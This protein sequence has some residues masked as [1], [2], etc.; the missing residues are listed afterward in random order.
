M[1]G[2]RVAREDPT[3][4]FFSRRRMRMHRIVELTAEN[5]K[6][7]RA[8]T[9]KPD[10]NVVKISGANGAGKS[11]IMDAARFA[12]QGAKGRPADPVRHGTEKATVKMAMKADADEVELGDLL[13]TAKA[14]SKATTVEVVS[15]IKGKLAS[16]QS[17]LDSLFGQLTFDPGEFMR[18]KPKEQRDMLLRVSGVGDQLEALDV[19]YKAVFDNR[20]IINRDVTMLENTWKGSG[21]AGVDWDAVPEAVVD[22]AALRNRLADLVREGADRE[23]AQRSIDALPGKIAAAKSRVDRLVKEL[24]LARAELEAAETEL[25]KAMESLDQASAAS[26][27]AVRQDIERQI[28]E[29]EKTNRLVDQRTSATNMRKRLDTAVAESADLTKRLE[30]IAAD[31]VKLLQSIKLPIDGLGFSDGG[32]TYLGV[33]FEDASSAQQITASVGI[34]MALNPRVRVMYIRNASLFD[35]SQL[36]MISRMAEENDYQLWLEIVDTSG[37]VGVYIE[38]GQ[39]VATN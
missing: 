11:S 39:I 4:P 26:G 29:A 5:F 30:A 3:P 14:T 37:T 1:C 28:A 35:S 19:S 38:E 13:I 2:C 34:G 21:Y 12:A 23:A 10:G 6:K 32:V 15:K 8:V 7:L 24:E 16:P 9:I 25:D 36:A 31:K 18:M 17:V 20:T 27:L 33:P 22:V